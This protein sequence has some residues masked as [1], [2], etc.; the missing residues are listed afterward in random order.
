DQ[1]VPSGDVR[2]PARHGRLRPERSRSALAG[3]RGGRRADRAELRGGRRALRP[4]WRRA[5]RIL[6]DRG[7][8][9]AALAGRAQPLGREHVRVRQPRRLLA[10]PPPVRFAR[11]AP[12][13]LRRH[14]G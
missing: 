1:P 8:R 9:H 12:H 7:R 13:R 14:H 4:A 2:L 11:R 3:R 10:H 5:L 6:P